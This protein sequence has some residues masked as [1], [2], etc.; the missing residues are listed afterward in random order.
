MAKREPAAMSTTS[1]SARTCA[2]C[3]SSAPAKQ[4]VP[5]ARRPS[6]KSRPA[7]TLTTSVKPSVAQAAAA[8]TVSPGVTQP[9]ASTRPSARSAARMPKCMSRS[10]YGPFTKASCRTPS[11][12]PAQFASMST[13]PSIVSAA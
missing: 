5:S 11:S 7:S 9:V 2:A 10:T 8:R 6:T 1:R 3:P 12:K 4:T 13:C